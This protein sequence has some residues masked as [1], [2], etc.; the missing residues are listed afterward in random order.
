MRLLNT[1]KFMSIFLFVF[2]LGA[3]SYTLNKDD[4]NLQIYKYKVKQWENVASIADKFHITPYTIKTSNRLYSNKLYAGKILLIPKYK[5]HTFILLFP[6]KTTSH[7][8]VNIDPLY[9]I[10]IQ[11]LCRVLQ[12]PWI[13]YLLSNTIVSHRRQ[14]WEE[15]F[16][17]RKMHNPRPPCKMR[18]HFTLFLLAQPSQCFNSISFR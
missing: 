7:L 6:N 11:Q 14:W 15:W 17:T 4:N 9:T 18:Q 12:V 3:K 8:S 13:K 5:Q 10:R 2:C 16:L 1:L